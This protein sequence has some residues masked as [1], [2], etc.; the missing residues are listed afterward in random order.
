[1]P[2]ERDDKKSAYSETNN[3]DVIMDAEKTSKKPLKNNTDDEKLD[4]TKAI[5]KRKEKKDKSE[6]APVKGQAGMVDLLL[7]TNA[8]IFDKLK[9]IRAAMEEKNNSSSGKKKRSK[10]NIMIGLAKNKSGKKNNEPMI[11]I[12]DAITAVSKDTTK[13]YKA[14][15]LKIKEPEQANVKEPEQT[16]GSPSKK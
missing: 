2:R 5:P 4:H 6:T 7:R 15:Q 1:M 12:T 8:K 10:R 9:K 13:F 16:I 3:P 11:T 14:A